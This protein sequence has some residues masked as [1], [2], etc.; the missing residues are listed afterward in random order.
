[1]IL[2]FS[3]ALSTKQTVMGHACCLGCD[4]KQRP[5]P[6]LGPGVEVKP[7]HCPSLLPASPQ[8]LGTAL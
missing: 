7:R 6:C 1:M 4:L 3:A 2:G 8:C 5:G